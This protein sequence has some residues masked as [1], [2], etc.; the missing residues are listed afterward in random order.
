M[1]K[2]VSVQFSLSVVSNSSGP[3]KYVYRYILFN[4]K[5]ERKSVISYNIDE[6]MKKKNTWVEFIETGK[7]LAVTMG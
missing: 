5:E 3:P 4:F 6:Q 1:K 7:G 2:Y